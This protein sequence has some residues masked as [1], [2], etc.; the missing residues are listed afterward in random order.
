MAPHRF[1][2]ENDEALLGLRAG[3]DPGT[4]I[5]PNESVSR[6]PKRSSIVTSV[7]IRVTDQVRRVPP[8]S[9]TDASKYRVPS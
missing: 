5:L 8:E 6:S 9:F 7:E 2:I 4:P 3:E 1:E